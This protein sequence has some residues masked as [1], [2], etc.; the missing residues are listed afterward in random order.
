MKWTPLFK[1]LDPPLGDTLYLL[2]IAIINVSSQTNATLEVL[3]MS[4][5]GFGLAG[6]TVLQK[7]LQANTTL[8]VLDLT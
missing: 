7:A 1:I 8:K 3:D 4:W 6:A 2:L 5:N